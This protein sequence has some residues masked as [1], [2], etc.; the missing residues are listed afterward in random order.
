MNTVH[1]QPFTNLLSRKFGR[2]A[3]TP[4]APWFQKLINRGYVNLL[5]LEMSEFDAPE[6]YPT[7]NALFTRALKQP[8]SFDPSAE[9]LLSP[10]DALITECGEMDGDRLLQIK[11]MDYSLARL[12]K[13]IDREK[14]DALQG[15]S[16][17]NFYL[18]PKDYHRYHAPAAM[19]VHTA[20]H[21]PGK[22]F[23]VNF[24]YLN[25]KE[26]LFVQNER[27][28]L[29]CTAENGVVFYMVFVGALNVG[30]IHLTFEPELNTNC[31]RETC[32]YD[33]DGVRLEK[34]EEL[35]MFKMGSTIVL[36]FPPKAM[37]PAVKAGE[38]V[39]FAQ[40]LGKWRG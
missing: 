35:G 10:C 17:L 4:H 29:E 39:R 40:T 34:G 25:R 15:G 8:R 31:V 36:L 11:G 12:L 26:E 6:S 21:I 23:P 14:I 30:K 33:Y 20:L 9:S 5:G 1:K 2:F 3:E 38:K 18:S 22:L 28:I 16:Y 7:L 27:V 32:R 24:K 19:T 13:G 37:E